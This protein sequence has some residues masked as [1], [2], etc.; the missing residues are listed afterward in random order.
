MTFSK[1]LHSINYRRRLTIEV[2]A[3]GIC[4]RE[5][6]S[7]DMGGILGTRYPEDTAAS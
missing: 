7:W 3:L 1:R 6:A 4:K 5:L 2:W